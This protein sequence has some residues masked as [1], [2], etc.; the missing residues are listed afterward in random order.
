M[1]Y[2]NINFNNDQTKLECVGGY[3]IT[4]DG[5]I[6]YFEDRPYWE[7]HADDIYSVVFY[8]DS[9]N[10]EFAILTNNKIKHLIVAPRAKY[11]SLFGCNSVNPF[12]TP[13]I[14]EQLLCDYKFFDKYYLN[15]YMGD[16]YSYDINVS[17]RLDYS[18]IDI[19][20]FRMYFHTR[21]TNIDLAEN[22]LDIKRKRNETNN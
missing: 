17:S 22:L 12:M 21:Q 19:E 1:K 16:P 2:P 11:I 10:V 6:H 20:H 8:K 15:T 14:L 13:M 7:L 3:L 4:T 5:S 18:T 9:I